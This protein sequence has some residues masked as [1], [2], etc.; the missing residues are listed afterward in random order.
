MNTEKKYY[1]LISEASKML[2]KNKL[3]KGHTLLKEAVV[4]FPDKYEAYGLLGDYYGFKEDFTL[5]LRN[6]EIALEK[7]PASAIACLSVGKC[8]LLTGSKME[9]INCLKQAI[10]IDPKIKESYHLLI[11][12]LI[13]N[14][15]QSDAYG[16][17]IDAINLHPDD[18][19][20]N[21]LMANKIIHC[22]DE[23]GVKL[24]NIVLKY[25]DKAENKGISSVIINSL[26]GDYY[27]QKQDWKNAEKY[28]SKCLSLE[29]DDDIAL[30][31]AAT[32]HELKK[33]DDLCELVN[34]MDEQGSE[35]AKQLMEEYPSCFVKA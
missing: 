13:E 26:R 2:R 7:N 4:L 25:L 11:P 15:L 17:L 6:H 20:I 10:N 24:T 35:Y 1:S 28:L 5:S 34:T 21:F 33:Y 23:L 31:Y 22:H 29:Y 14:E 9:A 30:M 32:L 27:Y 8:L 3:E 12:A 16:Y 18:G 19:V